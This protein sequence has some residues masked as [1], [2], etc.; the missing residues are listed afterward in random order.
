MKR[1]LIPLLVL[2]FIVF[3]ITTGTSYA[4]ESQATQATNTTATAEVPQSASKKHH[5]LTLN[6]LINLYPL[7][8]TTFH[9]MTKPHLRLKQLHILML[10]RLQHKTLLQRSIIIH[11]KVLPFHKKKLHLN[12][13]QT[14]II[15][16]HKKK[17]NLNL[18]QMKI[19]HRNP[20][21]R[22]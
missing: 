5:Q 13:L 12:L 15:H 4:A 16:L 7:S 20:M 19:I 6:L 3:S 21:I 10:K 11:L 14:K 9:I 8:Q 18:L 2:C 17:L 22:R 1:Y